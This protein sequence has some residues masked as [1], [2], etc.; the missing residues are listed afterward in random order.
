M[1]SLS[2]VGTHPRHWAQVGS[3]RE[4]QRGSSGRGLDVVPLEF[5]M[6]EV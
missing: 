6:S 4:A 1:P 3:E 2:L 5:R